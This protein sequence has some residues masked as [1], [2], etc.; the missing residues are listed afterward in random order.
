MRELKPS[1]DQKTQAYR[2]QKN[3]FGLM[4]GLPEDGGTCPGAT[5]SCGGCQHVPEGRVTP[6]CYV[7][8]LL[9]I[10]KNVRKTLE[11]NT[12]LFR[13]STYTEKVVLL[14]REFLRFYKQEKKKN[15][16]DEYW[17]RIHWSGDIPDEE[18]AHALREAIEHV[19]FINFWGYTRSFF[20]VPI[21]A[22]LKNLRW[23]LSLDAVNKVEGLE[24]Y[25][26]FSHYGNLQISWMGETPLDGL[27]PCPVDIGK[28]ELENA[29]QK[30]KLCL[31]GKPIWF[32][33]RK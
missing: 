30:C 26:K 6:I 11:Y 29:C 7:E 18:Y 3:T 32:N 33:T 24:V 25:N 9:R 20:S 1:A 17:Y 5:G 14:L 4:P 28:M 19:P 2:G 12:E 23:Y 10:R 22:G 21:L 15:K 8:K 13:E 31:N 27:I 16:A